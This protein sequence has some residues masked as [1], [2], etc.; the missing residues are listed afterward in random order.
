MTGYYRAL[1][2]F[3][4]VVG[5]LLA[6]WVLA[7]QHGRVRGWL[8]GFVDRPWSEEPRWHKFWTVALVCAMIYVAG[9]HA[10]RLWEVW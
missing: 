10:W 4:S 1:V 2:A 3:H 6:L 9:G 8:L 7:L 5:L